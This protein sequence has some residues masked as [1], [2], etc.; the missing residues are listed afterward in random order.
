MVR[1]C[2]HIVTGQVNES[3]HT[4]NIDNSWNLNTH[5]VFNKTMPGKIKCM[6]SFV[7]PQVKT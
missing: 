7:V 5:K 1:K 6:I 3:I 2:K 4:S